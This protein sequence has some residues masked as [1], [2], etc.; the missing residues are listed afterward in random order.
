MLKINALV[1]LMALSVAVTIPARADLLAGQTIEV[2]YLFPTTGTIFSAAMD[3]VGPAG[4]LS[5]FA[6]FADIA[7]SDT[8][9]LIT[10]TRDAGVNNVAFDGFEFVDLNGNIPNFTNVTLDGATNYA[11]FDASRITIAANTIFVNVEDLAGLKGQIISLDIGGEAQAVPE[12]SS[13][14]LVGAVLLAFVL[15]TFRRTTA[16]N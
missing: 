10:T 11:G 16:S 3:I 4:T 8:N 7:V 12:P 13:V 15:A 14:L 1:G 9:I 6:G 2:T 5:N